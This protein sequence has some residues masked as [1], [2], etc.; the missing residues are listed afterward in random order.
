MAWSQPYPCAN[1]IGR[2]VGAPLRVTQ[3]RVRTLPT[4]STLVGPHAGA[5]SSRSV[6]GEAP[7]ARTP[8]ALARKPCRG[9]RPGPTLPA[10]A[11]EPDRRRTLPALEVGVPMSATAVRGTSTIPHPRSPER[12]TPSSAALPPDGGAPSACRAVA[13][14]RVLHQMVRREWRLLGELAGWAPPGE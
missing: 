10:P 7:R 8:A 12:S 14:Q 2:P 9:G 1:T 6:T 3:F 11:P 13:Y 5:N 4:P